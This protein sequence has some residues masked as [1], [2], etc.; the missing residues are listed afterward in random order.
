MEVGVAL[1]SLQTSFGLKPLILTRFEAAG[2]QLVHVMG[3]VPR[4]GALGGAPGQVRGACACLLSPIP[5]L[6]PDV[7]YIFMG[8]AA[9][10]VEGATQP[11]QVG[12]GGGQHCDQCCVEPAP[13][14]HRLE[15]SSLVDWHGPEGCE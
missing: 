6:R 4:N 11:R 2:W 10:E 3:V 5:S 7:V 13:L 8:F 12:R 14:G 9:A 15:V 1:P